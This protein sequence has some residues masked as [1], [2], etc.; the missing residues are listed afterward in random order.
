M[1]AMIEAERTEPAAPPPPGSARLGM[2]RLPPRGDRKAKQWAWTGFAVYVVIAAVFLGTLLVDSSPLELIGLG[3]N[4][5]LSLLVLVVGGIGVTIWAMWSVVQDI[6][7][8]EA[9]ET[10]VAWLEEKGGRGVALVL[11]P[12]ETREDLFARGQLSMPTGAPLKVETLLDDRVR[13][14]HVAR[15]NGRGVGVSVE[16]MRAVAER[17]TARLG[18]FARYAS[19]LLLLLAVVG[20]F[21]GVKTALPGLISAVNAESEGSQSSTGPAAVGGPQAGATGAAPAAREPG[22]TRPLR[23]VSDAFGG[24]ALALIGA[25]ALGIMAQGLVVG[26]RNLLERLELVSAE[27]VY[28]PQQDTVSD[29]LAAAVRA[30]QSTAEEVHSTTGQLLGIEAGLDTLGH[31]FRAALDKLDSRLLQVLEQQEAGLHER[32]SRSLEQLELRVAALAASVDA[33]ARAYSGLIDRIGER[34][35]ESRRAIEEMTRAS[36]ALAA[37]FGAVTALGT[38]SAGAREQLEQ[39]TKQLEENTRQVAAQTAALAKA[40]EET[41][42]T[43]QGLERSLDAAVGRME[44]V[45]QRAA[46]SWSAVAEEMRTKLV[47]GAPPAVV[48]PRPLPAP[49]D[50]QP[51]LREI[52]RNTAAP[53][54]PAAPPLSRAALVLLPMGGLVL[55]GML[56]LLLERLG[57]LRLLF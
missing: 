42:P 26:R 9:E 28:G 6:R 30:L 25:I 14:T 38:S 37:A 40:I 4:P 2:L 29:P 56:L 36:G 15:T 10:D 12:A 41:A 39:S 53:A 49:P 54:A 50:L 18:G 35:D 52:A 32:T 45:D 1:T 11:A 5:N 44:Q 33:N 24:N 31:D 51:L 13:R 43:I 19:T 16:E 7:T 23:A 20:T 8:I 55:G 22:L 21:A 48:E 46:A 27:Y 3:E 47:A 57:L 17:R 34:A